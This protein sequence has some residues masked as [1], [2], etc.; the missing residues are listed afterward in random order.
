MTIYFMNRELE[1]IDLP[2]TIEELEEEIRK[3]GDT[4]DV[5]RYNNILLTLYRD[6]RMKELLRILRSTYSEKEINKGLKNIEK[7]V[8]GM[9]EDTDTDK[10]YMMTPT[11]IKEETL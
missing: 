11:G 4:R 3:I 1:F 8:K 6:G 5:G 7:L 10:T 2:D 9:E